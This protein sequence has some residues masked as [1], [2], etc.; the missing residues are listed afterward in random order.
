MGRTQIL[1]LAEPKMNLPF[2]ILRDKTC[3]NPECQNRIKVPPDQARLNWWLMVLRLSST[4]VLAAMVGA[5]IAL[6]MFTADAQGMHPIPTQQTVEQFE[7]QEDRAEI[8]ILRD[9]V[10]DQAKDIAM[11]KGIG[12]GLSAILLVLQIAQIAVGK[13]IRK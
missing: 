5:V 11:M 13:N 6:F 2:P 1:E 12:I 7:I 3:L 10:A 9:V 4:V 8:K